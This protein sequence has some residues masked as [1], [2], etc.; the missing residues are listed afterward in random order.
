MLFRYIQILRFTVVLCFTGLKF[1]NGV[2]RGGGG[3][4]LRSVPR[5]LGRIK[6][7]HENVLFLFSLL[8]SYM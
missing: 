6:V 1:G 3:D 7:K 8:L 2:G 5:P 4:V